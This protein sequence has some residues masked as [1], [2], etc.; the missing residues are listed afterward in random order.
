MSDGEDPVAWL[1]AQVEAR[2]ALAREA[3]EHA[4]GHWWRRMTDAGHFDDHRLEPVGHLWAGEPVLDADGD[5]TGGGEIVV[6]D[7]GRPSDAQFD[8]IAANDPRDVIAR[9]EAELAILD[10]HQPVSVAEG[11]FVVK[12]WQECQECGPNNDLSG[13]YAV[14]GEGESFWPCQTLRILVGAYKHQP[15]FKAEWLP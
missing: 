2:K 6:Y 13:V 7:E 3:S 12:R 10:Q 9:C 14:P 1:R 11:E 8:H 15:G 4:D 5:V